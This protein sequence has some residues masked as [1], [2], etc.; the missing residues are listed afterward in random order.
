M[1]C[2][3]VDVVKSNCGENCVERQKKRYA[4]PLVNRKHD[5]LH[6]HD[7]V[8]KPG[9]T[10]RTHSTGDGDTWVEKILRNAK[11]GNV[12]T[13]FVSTKT[14]IKYRNEPPTGAST[15]VYLKESVRESILT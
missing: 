8:A 10:T 7:P 15:V 4:S 9:R 5:T 1:N 12:D 6:I 2:R 13:F 14:G 11:N 3:R